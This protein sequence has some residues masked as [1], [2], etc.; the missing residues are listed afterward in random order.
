[1]KSNMKIDKYSDEKV[2]DLI[3]EVF[4]QKVARFNNIQESEPAIVREK[5]ILTIE[6]TIVGLAGS[7]TMQMFKENKVK[8][9]NNLVVEDTTGKLYL[10]LVPEETYTLN[11]NDYVIVYKI[12]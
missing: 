4:D 12:V 7:P 6:I 9:A 8:D 5:G 2:Q 3:A 10:T 11:S 1:M